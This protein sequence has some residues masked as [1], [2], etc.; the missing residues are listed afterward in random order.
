MVSV[1]CEDVDK[2]IIVGLALGEAD[3]C[4][5]EIL[6]EE[7]FQLCLCVI[8]IKTTT[9]REQYTPHTLNAHP[10]HL[11][12]RALRCGSLIYVVQIPLYEIT[13]TAH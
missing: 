4:G 5:V 6:L 13:V 9:Y 3:G 10:R 2:T 11:Q 7:G 12:E 1:L 8:L